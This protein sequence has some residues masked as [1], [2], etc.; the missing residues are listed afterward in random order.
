LS[1]LTTINEASK[2][3]IGN[4]IVLAV[5]FASLPLMTPMAT[6]N[7]DAV[8]P[9]SIAEQLVGGWSLFSRVTTTEGGKPLSDPGLSATP[10]GV[11]IYDR[12]EN[13]CDRPLPSNQIANFPKTSIGADAP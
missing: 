7:A 3:R 12:Y 13:G 2:M 5:L 6:V 11:L 10:K 1:A 9:S 4:P 8:T